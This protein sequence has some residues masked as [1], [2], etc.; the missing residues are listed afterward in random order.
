MTRDEQ[1]ERI[2][3]AMAKARGVDPDHVVSVQ[4][5]KTGAQ[6][7]VAVT[8]PTTDKVATWTLFIDDAA[9]F[10]AAMDAYKEMGG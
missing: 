4:N 6:P 10:L 5:W 9:A 1:I 7:H 2:A 8:M 3:R